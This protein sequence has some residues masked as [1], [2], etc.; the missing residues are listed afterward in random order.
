MINLKVLDTDLAPV[1]SIND[2]NVNY[3]YSVS[4][5][6]IMQNSGTYDALRVNVAVMKGV[7]ILNISDPPMIKDAR[8]D[9]PGK[10]FLVEY[11]EFIV[12]ADNEIVD[13][14]NFATKKIP[15]ILDED[16]YCRNLIKGMSISFNHIKKGSNS[17]ILISEGYYMAGVSLD[18]GGSPVGFQNRINYE[19]IAVGEQVAFWYRYYLKKNMFGERNPRVFNLTIRGEEDR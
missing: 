17:R 11:F 6:L 1:T 18:D 2:G 19:R 3:P 9:V 15:V 12:S 7:S 10:D 14:A 13:I 5:Q 8:I 16:G 4:R